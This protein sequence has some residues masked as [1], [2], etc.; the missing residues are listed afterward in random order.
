[1]F[2]LGEKVDHVTRHLW[3]LTKVKR[4]NLKVIRSLAYP[5]QQEG[6]HPLTGQRAANFR[7]PFL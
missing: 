6:Q 7:L 1:M 5:Q 2:K 3:P 4:S